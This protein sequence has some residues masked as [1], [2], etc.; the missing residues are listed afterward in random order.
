MDRIRVVQCKVRW[1]TLVKVVMMLRTLKVLRFPRLVNSARIE[2]VC[3]CVLCM[4]LRF[5]LAHRQ[6]LPVLSILQYNSVLPRP[7]LRKHANELI[8]ESLGFSITGRK[9]FECV[10]SCLRT[11]FNS[12]SQM[13]CICK[14]W[15]GYSFELGLLSNAKLLTVLL[16]SNHYLQHIFQPVATDQI[17]SVTGTPVLKRSMGSCNFLP[18]DFNVLKHG[19]LFFP[20]RDE[21][22]RPLNVAVSALTQDTKVRLFL[23]QSVLRT[24]ILNLSLTVRFVLCSEMRSAHCEVL[25]F[26]RDNSGVN[27]TTFHASSAT[28]C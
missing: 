8:P 4:P 15:C 19:G 28:V 23:P 26:V 11:N 22:Q 27:V 12:H 10:S 2:R 18:K 5:F 20:K 6:Q 24:E 17:H 21:Q 9:G 25:Y 16:K 13:V 14:I 1:P 7:V 3:R